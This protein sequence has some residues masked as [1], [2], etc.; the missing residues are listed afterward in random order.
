MSEFSEKNQIYIQLCRYEESNPELSMEGD[1]VNRYT[2]SVC[3][4]LVLYHHDSLRWSSD[5]STVVYELFACER[6]PQKRKLYNELAQASTADT[7]NRTPS[8]HA[9][10]S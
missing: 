2:I 5:Q 6:K 3:A 4:W 9:K 10:N 1:N 7:R 8:C